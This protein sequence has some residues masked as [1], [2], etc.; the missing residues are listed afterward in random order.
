MPKVTKPL[1]NTEINNARGKAKE[2]N[3]ADGLGLALRVRSG[4]DKYWIFNYQRPI[5]KVRANISLDIYLKVPLSSTRVIR[6]EYRD[7]LAQGIDPK[8]HRKKHLAAEKAA[9]AN[10]LQKVAADWLC[11]KKSK[12]SSGHADDIWREILM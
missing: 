12:V 9:G 6:S 8:F 2:Y 4:G 1:T 11:V 3:L 10:T 7:L 5:T